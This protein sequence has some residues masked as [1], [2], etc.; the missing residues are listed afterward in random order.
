MTDQM[1]AILIPARFVITIGHL[2]AMTSATQ[3]LNNNIK[4]SLMDQNSSS[5]DFESLN[6]LAASA[7]S[8]AY[9]CFAI[10]MIGLLVGL[11]IFSK[12]VNL[13]HIVTHFAGSVL[14]CWFICEYWCIG[15]FVCLFSRMIFSPLDRTDQHMK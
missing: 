14:T 4:T 2:L 11:S 8:L 15:F 3:T 1:I 12:K 6:Q 9:V 7:I 13:F 10:D 5:S